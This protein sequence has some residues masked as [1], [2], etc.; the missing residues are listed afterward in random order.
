M[1]VAAPQLLPLV[2]SPAVY[3][4]DARVVTRELTL[5]KGSPATLNDLSDND[6]DGFAEA[7]FDAVYLMGV[8]QT[9]DHGILSAQKQLLARRAEAAPKNTPPPA[10]PPAGDVVPLDTDTPEVAAA[11]AAAKA[12]AAAAAA[13]DGRLAKLQEDGPGQAPLEAAVGSPT[14]IIDYSVHADLGG[15]AALAELRERLH[16]RGLRVFLDF[17][18]NHMAADHPWTIT[19]PQYLVRGSPDDV[20]RE[21]HNYYCVGEGAVAGIYAHGRD[22]YFDG[23]EDTVQLNYASDALQEEMCEALAKVAG[24]CDGVRCEMA[25]LQC[26]SVFEQTWKQ[27]LEGNGISCAGL[28][29]ADKLFWPRAVQAA[30]RVKEDFVLIAEVYWGRE[31]ELQGYGFDFTL[32]KV[33]YEQLRDLKTEEFRQHASNDNHQFHLHSARFLETHSEK[34]ASTVFTKSHEEA[35]THQHLAAAVACY[36][37]PGMKMVC[38]GQLQGRKN[39]EPLYLAWRDNSEQRDIF[40]SRHQF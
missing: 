13:E 2:R 21:P 8:W 26:P 35:G 19:N 31:Y 33:A 10:P 27:H 34:R 5:R 30:R 25:M 37:M 38:D 4:L 11:K 24:M 3:Q 12:A 20:A 23:W 18:S 32:D 36:T 40:V 14:A 15:D 22:P 17:V 29:D 7:G 39:Q 1:C 6:L 16:E 9:G 28:A